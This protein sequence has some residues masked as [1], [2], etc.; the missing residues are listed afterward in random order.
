MLWYWF[1]WFLS[2]WQL[3]WGWPLDRDALWY[4]SKCAFAG[5]MAVFIHDAIFKYHIYEKIFIKFKLFGYGIEPQ[6]YSWIIDDRVIMYTN[7]EQIIVGIW[8]VY[9]LVNYSLSKYF[10]INFFNI[11]YIIYINI[12]YDIYFSKMLYRFFFNK[13]VCNRMKN[14]N[15]NIGIIL[16]KYNLI[17]KRKC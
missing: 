3:F 16:D 9:I 12:I 4:L 5:Y 14:I 13:Q 15:I 17:I 8:I 10:L 7:W 11:N 6:S 2:W 1:T